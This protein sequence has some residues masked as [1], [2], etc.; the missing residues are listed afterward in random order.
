MN[1]EVGVSSQVGEGSTFWFTFRAPISETAPPPPPAPAALS[2]LRVLV[3]DDNRV[4]LRVLDGQLSQMGL[5]ICCVPSGQEALDELHGAC[6]KG[7]PYNLAVVDHHMPEMTGLE[8]G[9][10]I[11]SDQALSD[12]IVTVLLSSVSNKESG[13]EIKAAG[14]AASLTKP[15]RASALMDSLSVA[16]AARRRHLPEQLSNLQQATTGGRK[17][18]NSAAEDA[19][20]AGLRVL[21]AEDNLVNQKVAV[22]MLEKLGCQVD[23]AGDGQKAVEISA[24]GGHHLILMDCQMPEMDGY[25]AT[26]EIRRSEGSGRHLPIIALTANAMKGDREKCLAAGMDDYASKPMKL[27]TLRGVLDRWGHGLPNR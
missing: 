12:S 14:F 8:L 23:V 16:W 19:P 21:L 2:G 4:N 17:N 24:R 26:A 13:E 20:Y 7:A 22:G 3:V 9:R 25:Q 1:G 6:Q 10:S 15:V 27:D 11:Q 5:T 18:N